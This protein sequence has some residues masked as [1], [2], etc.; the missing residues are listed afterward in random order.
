L[1]VSEEAL[2]F[3]RIGLERGELLICFQLLER[4]IRSLVDDSTLHQ[5]LRR[6]H[7]LHS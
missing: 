2:G 4:N 3:L 6:S 1:D 5:Q 7:P